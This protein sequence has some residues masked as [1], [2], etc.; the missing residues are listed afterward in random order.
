MK[1]TQTMINVT[2]R[3]VRMRKQ[4]SGTETLYTFLCGKKTVPL[5]KDERFLILFKTI[6]LLALV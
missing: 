2:F 5:K 3:K 1:I 4:F 6:N